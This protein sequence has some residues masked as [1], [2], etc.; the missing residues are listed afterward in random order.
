MLIG[1]MNHPEHDVL[2]DIARMA[3]AGLEFVDLTLEPP[4]AASWNIDVKA[5]R[6]ALQRHRMEVVGHTAWYL[7]M[8]SAIPEIRKAAVAELRRCLVK[9]GDIGAKWMNIHPDRHTPWHGRRF[10]IERNLDS[11]R[12][13]LPDSQKA[14]VGLMIENLP[15]DY[16]SA[17]QLGELLDAMPDLGL[18]LDI[19]HANLQV[20]HNT[21]E[22]I[23]AAYGNRLRH[24]HLHDNKGGHADLHLPLG[25][26]TVDL[27]RGI[28][29][30]QR[31]GYDGTITLEV[32]TPDP[33]HLIYSRDLLR[34][35]W[36]QS[37]KA[38]VEDAQVL[39]V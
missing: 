38:M 13:L 10:Y 25:T 29:A 9:F 30:L 14:G 11:L 37:R 22:E 39:Q 19:G 7:P 20:P 36:N 27:R 31:C 33:H 23:L 8:A 35:T 16:N 3:D 26:G 21:T 15:G 17:P 6:A 24:V 32:F 28:D 5:I 18:H 12:E 2:D 34:A 1:T 4:G